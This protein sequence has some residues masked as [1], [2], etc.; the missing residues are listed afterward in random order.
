MNLAN[1]VQCTASGPVGVLLWLQVCL[2]DRLQDQHC[3]RLHHTVFN[4]WNAQRSLLAIRF[5]NINS[6]HRTRTIRF[7]P[8]FVR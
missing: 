5:G 4:R 7:P 2:E 8:E 1:R 6:P 3:R